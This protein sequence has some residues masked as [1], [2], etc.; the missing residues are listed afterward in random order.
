LGV[1]KI[2]NSGGVLTDM[3]TNATNVDYAIDNDDLETTA[4]G[5]SAK[6]YLLGLQDGKMTVAVNVDPTV[7]ALITGTE[8][9]L[10]AGTLASCSVEYGPM[11]STVGNPKYTFEAMISSYKLNTPVGGLVTATL[12]LQRTGAHTRATY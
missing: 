7:D 6:A 3:S 8:A 5:A 2:D 12:E 1:I 9:A 10:R 4:F 11:G